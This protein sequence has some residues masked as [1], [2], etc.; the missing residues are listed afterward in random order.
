MSRS[1]RGWP[2]PCDRC[3]GQVSHP[4]RQ[5]VGQGTTRPAVARTAGEREKARIPAYP[6][7]FCAAV[8]AA[9]IGGA[10]GSLSGIFCTKSPTALPSGI[11][12]GFG[13]GKVMVSDDDGDDGK[14]KGK[15]TQGST[16][17]RPED[18]LDP[19]PSGQCGVSRLGFK[20]AEEFVNCSDTP[21]LIDQAIND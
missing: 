13:E 11:T 2:K 8:T 18:V 21:G 16:G 12:D 19:W 15:A 10:L 9:S 5:N 6:G 17:G 20:V 1:V 14:A 3:S 7:L 4:V